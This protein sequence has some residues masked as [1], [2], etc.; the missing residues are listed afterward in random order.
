[1]VAEPGFRALRML[2]RISESYDLYS[3]GKF[4]DAKSKAEETLLIP[5]VW[6]DANR[7]V[8]VSDVPISDLHP[9]LFAHL[10]G[11]YVLCLRIIVELSRS[12][13][14]LYQPDIQ[15]LRKHANEI[16]SIARMHVTSVVMEELL[17][18]STAL[19]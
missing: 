12:K 2:L 19:N 13:G 4:V 14:E 6:W 18:L 1:M 5:K 3:K 15:L 9:V 11:F 16:M 8:A 7:R 17:K 10:G